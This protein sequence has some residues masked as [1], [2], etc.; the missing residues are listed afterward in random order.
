MSFEYERLKHKSS[1]DNIWTPYSDLFMCI[2]LIFIFMYVV[3]ILRDT[4]SSAQ[5]QQEIKELKQLVEEYKTKQR[6]YEGLTKETI[7][8][9]SEE[10]Q[11]A[12][13][14]LMDKLSLLKDE[15]SQE[16]E[17]LRQQALENEKKEVALNKYQQLIRNI[18]NTNV[19]A[20]SQ[21]KR[22]DSIIEKKDDTIVEN[23]QLVAELETDVKQKEQEISSK[24]RE[25]NRI[26]DKLENR[27]AEIR[28]L[29]NDQKIS[30]TKMNEQIQKLEQDSQ[31]RIQSLQSERAKLSAQLSD[32]GS[33]LEETSQ[34]LAKTKSELTAKEREKLALRGQLEDTKAKAAAEVEA[35]KGSAAKQI[36]ALRA[37]HAQKMADEKSALEA[38]LNKEKLTAAQRA[39][40]EGEFRAQ[41]MAAEERLRGQI[42]GLQGKVSSQAGELTKAK[43]L[44]NARKRVADQIKENFRKA[45]L[46]AKVDPNTGDVTLSFGRDNFD[47]GQY[48]LKPG[49]EKTLKSFVPLYAE[50]LFK[51]P[52]I[53]EKIK[54]V[55]VVGFASPTYRGKVVDPRSLEKEDRE[56]LKYNMDLSYKRAKSIFS[57]IFDTEKMQY[58]HQRKLM[59]MVKVSGKSFLEEATRGRDIPKGMTEKEFCKQFNCKE[60]QRVII[61]F[62]LDE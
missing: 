19:L 21:I 40:R 55:E 25:I 43:E 15:A 41:A 50:S 29:Y 44:M 53:A 5:N 62:N 13:K 20:K 30:K 33:E 42:A 8:E 31:S 45:G 3:A 56:A 57:Y 34:T 59:P 10:E 46:E 58:N 39:Q 27:V 14:N 35:V 1:E 38:A 16:K 61:K 32:V 51:D 6:V 28:R 22:R 23:K 17:S 4:S 7:E 24:D 9:S 60:A 26:S 12:Y 18:I 52:K 47:T 11:D 2:S 36:E 48:N 37:A 49:M 54:S